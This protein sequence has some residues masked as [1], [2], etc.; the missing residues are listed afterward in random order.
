VPNKR[1]FLPVNWPASSESLSTFSRE[2]FNARRQVNNRGSNPYA[3]ATLT[4]YRPDLAQQHR[5]M[6][7]EWWRGWD[8]A[9]L[10]H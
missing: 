1:S 4:T 9:H 6:A 2:G 5:E 10:D 8:E 3:F 7:D